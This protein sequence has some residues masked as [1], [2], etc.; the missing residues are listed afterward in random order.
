MKHLWS[1]EEWGWGS[2]SGLLSSGS[3]PDLA[4]FVSSLCSVLYCNQLDRLPGGREGL[5]EDFSFL[6]ENDDDHKIC[7]VQDLPHCYSKS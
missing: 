6:S 1:E 3:D 2:W 7:C 4:P 5:Y